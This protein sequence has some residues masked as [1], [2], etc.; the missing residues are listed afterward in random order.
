MNKIRKNKKEIADSRFWR[1]ILIK[2]KKDKEKIQIFYNK[3]FKT[4]IIIL[5][6]VL[7]I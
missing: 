7:I 2:N 4:A 6:I 5:A 1:M 3:I